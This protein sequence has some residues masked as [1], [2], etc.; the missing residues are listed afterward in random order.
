MV[1]GAIRRRSVKMKDPVP[2][3]RGH[4]GCAA[5]LPMGLKGLSSGR[6]STAQWLNG[7]IAGQADRHTLRGRKLCMRP[8]YLAAVV[9]GG[10]GTPHEVVARI[11]CDVPIP[12]N[13]P[14]PARSTHGPLH[15]MGNVR[16]SLSSFVSS[17]NR[18]LLLKKTDFMPCPAYHYSLPCTQFL[19]HSPMMTP[20]LP[21][22]LPLS[23]PLPLPLPLPPPP[24]FFSDPQRFMT[25]FP[26]FYRHN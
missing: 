13:Q 6:A 4:N 9:V 18:A 10:C 17:Y 25:M 16:V 2:E 26:T 3:S 20:F 5:P 11:I 1:K 21:L 19:S 23:L 14:R 8:R 15:A 22:S 24:L 12:C 7:W